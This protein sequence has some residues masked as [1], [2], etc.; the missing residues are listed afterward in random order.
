MEDVYH[1]RSNQIRSEL[2][3]LDRTARIGDQS[4]VLP[5]LI[6][7]QHTQ[8][9]RRVSVVGGAALQWYHFRQGQCDQD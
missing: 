7:E 5:P 2:T 8:R 6:D 1:G 9:C 4:Q 3:Q